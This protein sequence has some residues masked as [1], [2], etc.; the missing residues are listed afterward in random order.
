MARVKVGKSESTGVDWCGRE[1]QQGGLVCEDGGET[2]GDRKKG[3]D[4]F[5]RRRCLETW[6][7]G[8][9]QKGG[10]AVRGIKEDE[11]CDTREEKRV[12]AEKRSVCLLS[13]S[14]FFN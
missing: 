5:N 9:R 12:F 10:M 3:D 8:R 13:L 7:R 11:L 1:E 4:V 6:R 14:L 2:G